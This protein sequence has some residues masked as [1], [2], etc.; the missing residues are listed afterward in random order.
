MHNANLIS[1]YILRETRGGLKA[2]VLRL[3]LRVCR[4]LSHGGSGQ[5]FSSG[6]LFPL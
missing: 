4:G 3:L 2:A 1:I 5:A 6:Q